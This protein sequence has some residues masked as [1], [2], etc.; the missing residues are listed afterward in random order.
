MGYPTLKFFPVHADKSDLGELRQSFS[1]EINVRLFS[2]LFC[3]LPLLR[4]I[5][6]KKK[7]MEKKLK[8][9]K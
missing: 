9:V 8:Y 2:K 5:T 4:L 7:Q 3:G 1:K 6:I